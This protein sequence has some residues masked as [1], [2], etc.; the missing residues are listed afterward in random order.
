MTVADWFL[1][2]P[3][4]LTR[5][6]A[7]V[8]ER[9]AGTGMGSRAFILLLKKEFNYPLSDHTSLLA[10][11]RRHYGNHWAAAN[12]ERVG[13]SIAKAPAIVTFHKSDA[14]VRSLEERDDFLITCAVNNAPANLD[15]L[16]ACEKWKAETGGAIII[17]PVRYQ[18]PRTRDEE[19]EARE[20]EWWAPE[21]EEY[22]LE[23]ELRPHEYLS[24]MPTKLQATTSNPL[25]PR[26]SGLTKHRSAVFGHPQ[27]CMR[28]V[29]TPQ[30]DLPKILYSSGAITE[31][32]YSDTLAGEL[33]HFHH[34]FSAV[35]AEVRG[36][37]FHLREVTWDGEQF[38]DI[39]RAYAKSGISDAPPAEALAMGDIH[40]GLEDPKVMNATFGQGGIVETMQ[41]KRLFLHDLCDARAVNPHELNNNLTRAAIEEKACLEAELGAVGRWLM[42]LPS[43]N[44][45]IVVPSNHDEFIMRWLQAGERHVEPQNR[46]LYHYLS[47]K[48]LDEYAEGRGFPN[49]LELALRDYNQREIRFL[50]VDESYQVKGIE[51]GMHGHLGP[52]GA[53]GTIRN[54]AQIGTRSVVMHVHSPGIWQGVYMGGLSAIYRHGYNR[55][56]SSWLQT[57]VAVLANGYRQMLHMISGDYRG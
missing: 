38:I 22:M 24:I 30:E 14:D 20:D 36:K 9:H 18:N 12:V 44:E 19:S 47:Y 3:Q 13:T 34:G 48:M 51:M 28:T 42:S 55:G 10:W 11:G 5:A 37:K 23:S 8:N 54:F 7:W 32:W 16:A 46:R 33:G 29:A 56:P 6:D 49:V 53:R 21:L 52:N 26:I 43:F 25:P 17:P 4:A 1:E 41:P 35:I 2:H 57:H 27:L 40:V 45:I 39:D 50:R 31:K 15:F